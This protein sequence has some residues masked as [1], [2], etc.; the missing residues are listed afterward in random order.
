MFAASSD[1]IYLI[2]RHKLAKVVSNESSLI[3]PEPADKEN[4]RN[5]ASFVLDASDIH[6]S[7]LQESGRRDTVVDLAG[8]VISRSACKQGHRAHSRSLLA[9]DTDPASGT[10]LDVPDA[11]QYHSTITQHG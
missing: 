4:R 5:G 8:C 10:I 1:Y 7:Q 3:G 9:H 11:T 6:A 2:P